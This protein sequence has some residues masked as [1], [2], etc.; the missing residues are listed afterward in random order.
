MP[1]ILR[2]AIS[3]AMVIEEHPACLALNEFGT[4][5]NYEGKGDEHKGIAQG[6]ENIICHVLHIF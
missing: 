1:V 4:E 5:E 3:T 6:F 2:K